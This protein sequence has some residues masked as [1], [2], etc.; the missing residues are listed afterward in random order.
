MC[1]SDHV[2]SL[3]T[4]VTEF[5]LAIV[6]IHIKYHSY[7]STTIVLISVFYYNNISD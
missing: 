2:V 5:S 3:L 1:R 7:V 4:I 6:I